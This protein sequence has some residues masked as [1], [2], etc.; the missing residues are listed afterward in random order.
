MGIQDGNLV[1]T[2]V[3]ISSVL[4]LSNFSSVYANHVPTDIDIDKLWSPPSG[5]IDG[6][7]EFIN[8]TEHP[9]LIG[10]PF[11]STPPGAISTEEYTGYTDGSGMDFIEPIANDVAT[12]QTFGDKA[13]F[14]WVQENRD[15]ENTSGS[16]V[17]HPAV[18]NPN[19][20]PVFFNLGAMGWTIGTPEMSAHTGHDH[21]IPGTQDTLPELDNDACPG[22]FEFVDVFSIISEGEDSDIGTRNQALDYVVGFGNSMMGVTTIGIISP[23]TAFEDM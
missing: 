6:Y 2:I 22:M 3:A 8:P 7:L 11:L 18:F 17:N 5:F 12:H 9:G 4:L 21:S 14:D 10:A 13:D 16:G 20:P 15:D 19:P 23:P 1:F